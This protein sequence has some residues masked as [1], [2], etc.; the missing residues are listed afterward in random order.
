VGFKTALP[1]E[2]FS[3]P[4]EITVESPKQTAKKSIE[5]AIP[6][7]PPAQG[8][9]APSEQTYVPGRD[10]FQGFQRVVVVAPAY[11]MLPGLAPSG[12]IAFRFGFIQGR[13]FLGT[14]TSFIDNTAT[15][16][17][18]ISHDTISTQSTTHVTFVG[19]GVCWY[20][21]N[22]SYSKY[23]SLALG[24]E[25]GYWDYKKQTTTTARN[26][27]TNISY[28]TLVEAQHH[29]YILGPKAKAQIGN[30]RLFLTAE[31]TLHIGGG[32]ANELDIGVTALF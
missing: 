21:E 16:D 31:Y 15:G 28:P 23:H 18:N 26:S 7:P 32:V 12:G 30:R 29:I 10:I 13:N 24:A 19:S 11:G 27:K 4:R 6:Q 9:P 22:L 20:A 17:L 8:A 3:T 5:S 1:P 25:G 2:A 14:T